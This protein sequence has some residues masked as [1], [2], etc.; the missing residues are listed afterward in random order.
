MG[1]VCEIDMEGATSSVRRARAFVDVTLAAWHLD[2]VRDRAVLLT[3]ELVTNAVVHARTPFKLA[4]HLDGVV[5]VEVTDG[6]PDLPR[7]E[8]VAFDEVRGRGLTLVSR[9]ASRW[10]TRPDP[11]GKTVWFVLDLD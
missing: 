1:Q 10:G 5:T 4:V 3:S 11:S 8:A 2:G 9:L 7:L 6:S